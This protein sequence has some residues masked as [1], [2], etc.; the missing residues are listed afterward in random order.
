M[1]RI[2][3]LTFAFV[4][5]YAAF[6]QG[7][8]YGGIIHCHSKESDGALSINDMAKLAAANGA[9]FIIFTDHLDKI[10][11]LNKY[12][13]QIHEVKGIVAIAG[14][15]ITTKW[16]NG[17]SHLLAL[18]EVP[19]NDPILKLSFYHNMQQ[20]FIDRL[21]ELEVLSTAA[22]PFLIKAGS[23]SPN[24]TNPTTLCFDTVH[25]KG[26]KSIEFFNDPPDMAILTHDWY[27]SGSVKDN[28]FVTAGCDFHNPVV[29]LSDLDK[30][31]YVYVEGELNAQNILD[32]LKNGRTYAAQN[33]AY[34]SNMTYPPEFKGFMAPF[35]QI[36]LDFGFSKK[37]TSAKTVNIYANGK[38]IAVKTFPK[39]ETK[40]SFD[41]EDDTLLGEQTIVFEIEGC[42]ITS[43]IRYVV[44]PPPE[45]VKRPE[46]K[47]G[48]RTPMLIGKTMDDILAIYGVPEETI[49]GRDQ[50]SWRYIDLKGKPQRGF[51]LVIQ[52]EWPSKKVLQYY[53][54]PTFWGPRFRVDD[55]LP[56]DVWQSEPEFYINDRNSLFMFWQN[57]GYS[58]TCLGVKVNEPFFGPVRELDPE[59]G[60]LKNH[61]I[62]YGDKWRQTAFN[63]I[64][65]TTGKPEFYCSWSLAGGKPPK[66]SEYTAP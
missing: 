27:V 3:V 44:N 7:Q 65:V 31:T 20:K 64:I 26:L 15:E 34:I 17:N 13:R 49:N 54:S 24:P 37:T 23:L 5:F 30:K 63:N 21:N 39:G 33:G 12:Y 38:K 48:I 28:L 1:R 66:L 11:D 18:G 53:F 35:S 57:E 58:V 41:F 32:A 9:E 62:T 43:P 61:W 52:F 25:A 14:L 19:A 55:C 22:H 50:K 42:L 46:S 4:L 51:S 47:S 60:V 40:Y 36:C 59:T 16:E 45:V 8:W 56:D 10:K 2:C 6:A 29:N